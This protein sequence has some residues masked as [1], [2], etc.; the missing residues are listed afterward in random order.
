MAATITGTVFNDLNHNGAIDATD[1]PISGVYVYLVGPSGM[2]EAVTGA[3]GTYSFNVATAG[4]YTVFETVAQNQSSPPV[5]F[6]QPAGFT[7]SN[8]ARKI[9]VAVTAAN[10]SGNAVLSGNNFAHDTNSN[11]LYCQDTFIQFV[12]DPT[13]WVSINLVTGE[14]VMQGNLSPAYYINAIGYNVLDNY[15]YGYNL[16]NNTIARIDSSGNVMTLG[17]PTGLPI[18]ANQYNT[19]CFDDSGFL[20]IY[21]GAAAKMYVIDLR[22]NSPTFMK[23]VDPTKSYAEQTSSYGITLVNGAPNV[24]DWVWLPANATTGI[25]TNGFLYGIQTGGTMYRVNLDNAHVIA[26]TTSG[27]VYNSSYG[28]MSVDASDNIYAVANQNGNIYRYTINDITTTGSYFS[29]TYYDSHNDGAMCRNVVLLIDYGD[30]PD[31]GIGT[32]P[33]NYNTLLANNGPRHQIVPGLMLGTQ[34][35]AE[36]DAYQNSDATGDDLINGIPDDGIATPLPVL[37]TN[38][39]DYRLEVTVTNNTAS[40][41]NLYGWVD[42]NQNGLF[43]IAESASATIPANSGTNNYMLDFNLTPSSSINPGSTFARIRLTTDQLVQETDPSGQDAASIGPASDGEVEDYILTISPVADLAVYKSA[44]VD[45]IQVG[46]TMMYT[47]KIVNYGPDAAPTPLLVDPIPP[48]IK[49]PEY[50]IDGGLTWQP[51]SQGSLLLP[52]L[53]SNEAITVLGRGVVNQ[54]ADGIIVNAASVS[55]S[56]PDPDLTNNSSVTNTPIINSADISIVK[57]AS[58]MYVAKDD[59]VTYTLA[60]GNAGPS[61]AV[62]AIVTDAVPATISN[63]VYSLDGGITQYPW[64]GSL[65]IGTLDAGS[66][67]DLTISGVLNNDNADQVSN[68]ASINSETPDPNQTNN[69]S[70]AQFDVIKQTDL[71]I[72]KQDAGP[73]TPPNYV[74][75]EEIVYNLVATNNGPYDATGVVVTDQ[76]SQILA[77]AQYSVDNGISWNSWPGQ[78]NLP[79]LAVGSSFNVIIKAVIDPATTSGAVVNTATVS[80]DLPDTD[81]SNNQSTIVSPIYQDG[82]IADL[83]IKKSIDPAMLAPGTDAVYTLIVENK[84]PDVAKNAILTDNLSPLLTSAWISTDGINWSLYSTPYPLGDI[85]PYETKDIYIKTTVDPLA[86]TALNRFVTNTA[87][88]TSDTFDENLDDNTDTITTPLRSLADM[89]IQKTAI[90]SPLVAGQAIVYQLTVNN[91]GPSTAHNV[92]VTDPF[93]ATVI[94]QVYSLN[95]SPAM[96]WNGSIALGDMAASAQNTILIEGTL[97][98]AATGTIHNTASVYSS[99]PDPDHSNNRMRVVTPINTGA[100][101]TITK[102][103]SVAQAIVGDELSYT[104][105]IF[106]SGPSY[107]YNVVIDDVVDATLSGVTYSLDGLNWDDWSGSYTYDMIPVGGARSILIKGVVSDL[108]NGSTLN[109]ATASADNA[110][111]TSDSVVVGIVEKADVAIVKSAQVNHVTPG[112][113][114]AF[115]LSVTNNGPSTARDVNVTDQIPP[116]LNNAVY[117]F[118]QVDWYDWEGEVGLGDLENTQSV[119][120]YIRGTVANNAAG[121]IINTALVTSATDDPNPN[122]NSSS[123]QVRASSSADLQIVKDADKNIARSGDMVTYTLTVTNNGPSDAGG[124]AV[125]D[126]IPDNIEEAQ[127]SLDGLNWVDWTS[128]VYIGTLEAGASETILA[129]G[130]ISANASFLSNTATVS[131]TTPDPNPSNNSSTRNTAIERVAPSGAD[132]GIEKTAAAGEVSAGDLLGYT[133]TVTNYGPDDAV[134]VVIADIM[135]ASLLDAQY[136]LNLADWSVWDGSYIL[137]QIA[138][139]DEFDLYLQAVVGDDAYSLI[140]NTATVTSDTMDPNPSNNNASTAIPVARTCGTFADL[141]VIKSVDSSSFAIGQKVTYEIS[142]QNLGPDIAVGVMVIDDVSAF[143]S[144]AQYS[145]NNGTSWEKW[146]KTLDLGDLDPGDV[147]FVLVSGVTTSQAAGANSVAVISRTADPDLSNNTA[148]LNADPQNPA[149]LCIGSVNCCKYCACSNR[150]SYFLYLANN[151]PGD[152]SDICVKG[153]VPRQF[154][155]AAC[156]IDN[157]LTWFGLDGDMMIDELDEYTCLKIMVNAKT[158]QCFRGVACMELSIASGGSECRFKQTLRFY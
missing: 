95:G 122:N 67:I 94:D 43:E 47:M 109:T 48:Q 63:P 144:G 91:L 111:P 7:L 42:F 86:S 4:S 125:N 148:T 88:V 50:S 82:D 110:P 80:S 131:S 87:T 139:G 105:Y 6:A 104:I 32:G 45:A 106:N 3:D 118:N 14:P 29:T 24:A 79:Y 15:I 127:M 89:K 152:A 156:S 78:Y 96:P 85:N 30:A 49:N 39:K 114:L 71:A 54:V 128:P 19:G 72:T 145:L 2:M 31:L 97:S 36:E 66:S 37:S 135:P 38:A 136:S 65:N 113:M 75:G 121:Q 5:L 102:K 101:L 76:I 124:V 149:N 35:T 90:T 157:G 142:V 99:T 153:L 100:N 119:L 84:G 26:M 70:T 155:D 53:Q 116:Q 52:T 25:G 27:P 93:P 16:T 147:A 158:R 140:S 73:A 41:A 33:G 22:P 64:T 44:S 8:G 69:T 103:A 74:P 1:V 11:P 62:N 141:L 107:A 129:R 98:P 56:V 10:I 126:D 154:C 61:A 23:L 17:L 9:P 130:I 57:T 20:Y 55:S 132:L 108:G 68:T 120:I 151:G 51:V 21:Y 133:I 115:T 146:D 77:S 13:T 83:D 123:Y 112:N 117:S 92:T 58:P 46:Q 143:L 18:T 12:N 34:V 60:I 137:A 28:A 40:G 138:A 81:E 59:T 134:N 150:C